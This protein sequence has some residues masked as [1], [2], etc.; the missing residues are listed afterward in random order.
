MKI[1]EKLLNVI[2]SVVS[3]TK[4]REKTEP[5]QSFNMFVASSRL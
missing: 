5:T 3:T 2:V 1:S 4:C